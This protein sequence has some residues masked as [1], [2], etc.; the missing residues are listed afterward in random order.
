MLIH[1]E[2]DYL[3]EN[4]PGHIGQA[5]AK[6]L[7]AQGQT[8]HNG[9]KAQLNFDISVYEPGAYVELHKHRAAE[10]IFYVISGQGKARVGEE[11][12][13]IGPGTLLWVPP[14]TGHAIVNTGTEPLKFLIIAYPRDNDP[15]EERVIVEGPPPVR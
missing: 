9:Y 11:V 2:L 15:W 5:L 6:T 13:L 10:E 4:P 8:E 14:G 12:T 1:N 3:W 7:I